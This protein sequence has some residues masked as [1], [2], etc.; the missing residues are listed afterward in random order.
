[1][2]EYPHWGD[3]TTAPNLRLKA[4][5]DAARRGASV[6]ILLNSGAFDQDSTDLSKNVATVAYVNAIAQQGGLD[7]QARMGDPTRYGIHS[8]IVLVKLNSKGGA[9]YSHVG[10]ING[11]ETS[12]KINREMAVQV[13]SQ[14]LY[15]EMM[16]VFQADWNLAAPIFLPMVMRD[17]KPPDH[18]LISEVYYSATVAQQW[19][20]LYN[21]TGLTI[22]LSNYKI[23]DAE[24]PD[25]Y[26]GM[27]RFPDGT[28]IAPGGVL[29][30]AYD[31]TQVPKA[32]LQMCQS[33]G[34]SV[35]AM[36]KYTAWG[37][38]DWTLAGHG[39]QVLLLG[40]NDVPVD[41][42]VYGDMSYPGVAAH[43]GVSIYTHSLERYP[44]NR[45]TENCAADFRDHYPTPGS[46]P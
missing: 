17:Y 41:V 11:S 23:G 5:L 34:G 26:E 38:G 31:A 35:P 36:P 30:I 27:F 20:E 8:K 44:A 33:C 42:V 40:P 19:V 15:A 7:L 32:N 46:V 13:E 4:Y 1:M 21:P 6:R 25:R 3:Y 37:S 14:S 18:L 29:V 10:S 43:P 16:R 12:S 45:D 28:Q 22:N 9:V 39:D 2:Y 24:T